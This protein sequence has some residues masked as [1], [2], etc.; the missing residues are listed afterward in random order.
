M[1]K[2]QISES[3]AV[4]IF[5]ALSGG[6]MDAYSYI[7]RGKVFANAETGNIV[8]MAIKICEKDFLSAVNYLI[9]IISFAVGVAASEIIKYRKDRISIVHWRQIL[10]LV[11]TAA[12]I[13]VAFLPQSMNRYANSVISMASGMQF[14]TF[15]KVRGTAMAT[16]MCTGNLKTGT[17]NLYR[18]IK[19]KDR[20][21]I[22]KGVYY[23]ICIIVFIIG[24]VLGYVAVGFMAEKA[25]LMAAVGMVAVFI[26]MFKEYE[27]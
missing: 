14:A 13:V 17:Q 6:F 9:P 21:T 24:T 16:T 22:E 25:I 12:F 18:G 8:L 10:A 15:P 23:Y 27:K 20:E 7:N 2:W 11:E 3:I 5:L 26:L 19:T 1:K 4:G